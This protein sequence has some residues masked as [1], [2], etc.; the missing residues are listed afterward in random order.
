MYCRVFLRF[1]NKFGNFQLSLLES[2]CR[3]I[4][5]QRNEKEI[6]HIFRENKVINPNKKWIISYRPQGFFLHA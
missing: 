2:A 6:N 3:N 5:E 4:S 1:H